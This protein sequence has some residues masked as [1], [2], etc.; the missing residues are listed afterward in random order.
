MH[1][2]HEKPAVLVSARALAIPC[3]GPSMACASALPRARSTRRAPATRQQLNSHAVAI[4]ES[5]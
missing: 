4:G 1:A 2:R 5:D 3:D